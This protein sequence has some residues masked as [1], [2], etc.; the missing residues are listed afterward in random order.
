MLS[1]EC[2]KMKPRSEVK[3]RRI[4][5]IVRAKARKA[6]SPAAASKQASKPDVRLLPLFC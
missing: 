5:M 4:V 3:L 6:L 2:F 1:R